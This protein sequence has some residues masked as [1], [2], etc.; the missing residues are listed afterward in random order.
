MIYLKSMDIFH[1]SKEDTAP[2]IAFHRL[3]VLET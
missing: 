1:F 3:D 2:D